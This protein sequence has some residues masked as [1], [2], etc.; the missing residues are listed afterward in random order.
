VSGLLLVNP[1]TFEYKAGDSL[2]VQ[3]RKNFSEARYYQR[4]LFRAS[5]WAK[6][7]RGD[8]D[9]SYI[10][11][12]LA[13]RARA[14]AQSRWELVRQSLVAAR[15]PSSLYRQ[16]RA[17]CDRG[18]RVSCIYSGDDPGLE[19]FREAVIPHERALLRHPGFSLDVIAGPDH[20][21]TPLWSQVRLGELLERRLRA[22]C[23]QSARP[24]EREPLANGSART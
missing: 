23:A 18:C 1:Q 24:T 15:V 19:H 10:A 12:V 8:V 2:E 9:F 3:R 5:S 7:L 22:C 11:G 4:S 14:V 13:T 17:L 6:A 21:F 16:L 20:T